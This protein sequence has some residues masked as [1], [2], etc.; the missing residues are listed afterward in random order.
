MFGRTEKVSHKICD[1][2]VV[3]KEGRRLKD[4]KMNWDKCVINGEWNY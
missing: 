2:Y 4:N 1:R 3:A